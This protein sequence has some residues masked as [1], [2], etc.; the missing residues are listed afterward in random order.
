[1][2][3]NGG[4][5]ESES[6][7]RNH[8]TEKYFF[9][10]RAIRVESSFAPSSASVFFT[11]PFFSASINFCA[12][13]ALTPSH[14]PH[15]ARI[16]RSRVQSLFLPSNCRK[17]DALSAASLANALGSSDAI[18]FLWMS[19]ASR[20]IATT[21]QCGFFTGTESSGTYPRD[22]SSTYTVADFEKSKHPAPQ[23]AWVASMRCRTTHGTT[24]GFS[25]GP[26]K[27]N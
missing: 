1:M 17:P 12:L 15:S 23:Y 25:N 11:I 4:I 26:S 2:H 24:P 21:D 5:K 16:R 19:C 27:K 3:E 18:V 8:L 20:T 14:L 6:D 22:P 9:L 10:S 7:S 13:D